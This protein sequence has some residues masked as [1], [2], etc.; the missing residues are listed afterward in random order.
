MDVCF[1]GKKVDCVRVDKG[2]DE[3]PGQLEIQ[4]SWTG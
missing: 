1:E 3:G 2:S 4:F